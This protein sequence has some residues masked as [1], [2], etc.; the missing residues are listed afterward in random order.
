L[1]LERGPAT[2][3][4]RPVAIRGRELMALHKIWLRRLG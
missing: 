2:L 4:M 1:E 3:E